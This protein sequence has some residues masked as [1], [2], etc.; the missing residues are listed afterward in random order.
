MEIKNLKKSDKSNAG[1]YGLII[2]FIIVAALGAF[3]YFTSHGSS[4]WET[5][6]EFG[7]WQD[8]L[9]VEYADGTTKS[10]KIIEDQMKLQYYTG[11]SEEITKAWIELSAKVEG[12]GYSGAVIDCQGFGYQRRVW[13][14]PNHVLV[15]TGPIVTTGKELTIPLGGTKKIYDGSNSFNYFDTLIGDQ[16]DGPYIVTWNVVGD[17]RYKPDPDDG[18][19]WVTC[20][21]PPNRTLAIVKHTQPTG[22]ILVTLFSD[23][24]GS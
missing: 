17:V 10:L 7:T 24:G 20:T 6:M 9:I 8:E 14:E 13:K 2:L 21:N 4:Y 16:P 15:H 12:T 5:E 22:Q 19:G 11:D 18:T 3:I 23:A 1:V